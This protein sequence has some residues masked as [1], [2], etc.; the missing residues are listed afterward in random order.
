[1]KS[2]KYMYIKETNEEKTFHCV[3]N[4]YGINEPISPE[5]CVKLDCFE[6]L[7]EPDPWDQAKAYYG[8]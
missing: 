7:E 4:P 2:C 1:M 6:E 3:R 8:I 5:E